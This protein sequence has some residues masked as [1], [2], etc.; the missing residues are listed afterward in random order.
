MS[1]IQTA[2][3]DSDVMTK[4][5]CYNYECQNVLVEIIEPPTPPSTGFALIIANLWDWLSQIFASLISFTITGASEVTPGT[6]ETYQIHLTAP[7]PDSDYSDGTFSTQYGYWAMVDKD[8][9][10]IDG[11]TAGV[12]V[13]G[14]YSVTAIVTIPENV[15]NHVI[16]ATITQIDSTYDFP[17]ST[18][19]HGTEYVVT[20]EA[21]SLSTKLPIPTPPLAGGLSGVLTAIWT[22][23]TGLFSWLW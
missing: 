14:V 23:I 12:E 3:D 17:T 1:E 11:E 8:G 13:D 4:D 10:I 19:I 6:S 18:W 20:K 16:M 22:W 5:I 15:N 2:C 21:I 9:N 7:V